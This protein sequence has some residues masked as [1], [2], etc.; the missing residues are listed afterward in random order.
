[1]QGTQHAWQYF[2]QIFC[3][4][5]WTKPPCAFTVQPYGKC[6]CLERVHMLGHQASDVPCKHIAGAG[7]R[8]PRRRVGVDDSPPVW[9]G[10]HCIGAL[11]DNDST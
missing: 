6:C 9:S 5:P 1:M 8:Q 4:E 2:G 10:G 11:Q 7:R 3:D